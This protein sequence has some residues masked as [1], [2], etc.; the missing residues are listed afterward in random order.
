[1]VGYYSKMRR[2][3]KLREGLGRRPFLFP[4]SLFRHPPLRTLGLDVDPQNMVSSFNITQRQR[5]P[6]PG[7]SLPGVFGPATLNPFVINLFNDVAAAYY[8]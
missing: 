5:S 4:R 2:K 8:V 3:K 6:L 7:S 1:M